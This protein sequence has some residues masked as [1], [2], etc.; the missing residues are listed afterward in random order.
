MKRLRV[1]VIAALGS[2]ASLVVAPLLAQSSFIDIGTL[3]PGSSFLWAVNNQNDAVGWSEIAG[4]DSEHAILW[5]DGAL[6]DLGVLPGFDVSGAF[7][8]NDRGQIVGA[9]T[10]F[11]PRE[12]RAV[13]WE[14]GRP[15][16]VTPPGFGDCSAAAI[17]NGGMIVGRC[18][19]GA[20]RLAPQPTPP[21][22]RSRGRRRRTS[23]R[24]C[25]P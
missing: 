12:T 2:F 11:D 6:I 9:S 8:I 22:R 13:L 25:L 14:D 10:S 18:G 16:D 1:C 3:G 5:R 23:A 24:R 20:P 7:G 17:N 15:I 4:S 21:R 19:P